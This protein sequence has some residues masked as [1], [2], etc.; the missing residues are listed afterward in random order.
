[1]MITD[2]LEIITHIYTRLSVHIWTPKVR[3]YTRQ[4]MRPFTHMDRLSLTSPFPRVPLWHSSTASEYDFSYL[5]TSS[6]SELAL[7]LKLPVE[8]PG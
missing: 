1:M 4:V 3:L 5:V 7:V 8:L 2:L 6:L